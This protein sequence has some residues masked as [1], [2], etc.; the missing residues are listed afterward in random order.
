MGLCFVNFQMFQRIWSVAHRPKKLFTLTICQNSRLK[1]TR[2][3]RVV[4]ARAIIIITITVTILIT[5]RTRTITIIYHL[6]LLLPWITLA[7]TIIVIR[8]RWTEPQRCYLQQQ[9]RLAKWQKPL[10]N[11][12]PFPNEFNARKMISKGENPFFWKIT[13]PTFLPDLS[14]QVRSDNDASEVD[15]LGQFGRLFDEFVAFRL[16]PGHF[17]LFSPLIGSLKKHVTD[18]RGRTNGRTDADGP[19]DGRTDRPSYRD[20][21]T[22]LNSWF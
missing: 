21:R 20:A 22:H 10:F 14:K 19:T 15:F 5:S 3:P 6:A 16:F 13:L 9:K 2:T 7:T 12:P 4:V 1:H 8:K 11:S 17:W 18:G